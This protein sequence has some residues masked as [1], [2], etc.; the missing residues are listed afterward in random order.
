MTGMN[1][2]LRR[3]LKLRREHRK[4][5]NWTGIKTQLPTKANP[6]SRVVVPT[7]DD[8]DSRVIDMREHYD[9]SVR[10]KGDVVCGDS[11]LVLTAI[12]D[13][14]VECAITSPPYWNLVDYG[15]ERQIGQDTYK[16]YLAAL[17]DVFS[18]VA[19][20]LRPNGKFCL[21]VPLMPL[22]KAVSA[23]HFGKTH[24]RM[25]LDL[26]GDLKRVILTYTPLRYYSLYVWE[27]QTTEKMFGSYPY[28][29]NL[30]ERNYI[31]FILVFVKPGKPRK[32][33][34]EVKEAAKLTSEE[35]MELTKQIWWMYPAN[36]GRVKGHPAPFPES[37]PNRLISMYTFPKAGDYAGDVVLDPFNGWGTTCIAAKRLGRRYLGIDLSP[38]F[39]NEAVERLHDVKRETG[40]MVAA[41]GG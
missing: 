37:L 10:L 28:P 13:E 39:C 20:T 33:P 26:P 9:D 17:G 23:E 19:R 27:K 21:N 30:L 22:T 6:A 29:P 41:P 1:D 35:W 31:E 40:I 38:Q 11:R 36:V 14:S 5:S 24:T 34:K 16:Q 8:L 18:E 2:R 15:C 4:H 32:M 7:A 3:R 25:I 12:P